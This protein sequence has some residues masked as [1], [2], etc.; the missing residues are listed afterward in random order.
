MDDGAL[1]VWIDLSKPIEY[2]ENGELKYHV[3]PV[4]FMRPIPAKHGPVNPPLYRAW[5]QFVRRHV[6]AAMHR[7]GRIQRVADKEVPVMWKGPVMVQA[8]MI[9]KRPQYMCTTKWGDSR[10][11]HMATPDGDN[12]LKGLTDAAEGLVY[13][14]DSRV[15]Q[16]RYLKGVGKRNDKTCIGITFQDLTL[17]PFPK[18]TL[19]ESMTIQ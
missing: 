18:L 10:E 7:S 16:G 9:F 6:L 8:V 2:R 5:L 4:A 3:G 12:V 14:N 11:F 19:P 13:P 17:I 15:S 1:N